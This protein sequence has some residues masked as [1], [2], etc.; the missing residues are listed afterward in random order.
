MQSSAIQSFAGRWANQNGSEMEI[1]VDGHGT[2][3]GVYRTAVGRPKSAEEFALSGFVNGDRIVFCVNFG[4]YGSLT[5]WTGRL[6]ADAPNDAVIHTLWHLAREHDGDGPTALW[7][8][9]LAG[10]SEFRRV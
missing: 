7:E 3:S 8:G 5:A 1:S 2:V 9:I 6:V 10:A 4:D